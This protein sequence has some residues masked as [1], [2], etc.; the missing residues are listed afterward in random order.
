MRERLYEIVQIGEKGDV[1]SRTYDA[2]I[3][4]M[5]VLSTVSLIFPAGLMPADFDRVVRIIDIIAVYF[6]I[7]DF[8]MRWVT[9]DIHRRR[10]GHAGTWKCFILYPFTPLAIID[11]LAVLPSILFLPFGGDVLK[12]LRLLKIFRLSRGLHIVMRVIVNEGRTL[13]SVLVIMV[14]FVFV[15]ALTLYVNEPE[16]FST[17]ID[18][19]YWSSAALATIGYGDLHPEGDVGMVVNI[20]SAI[21]GVAVIA[22]PSGIIAAG[23]A[24]EAQ[25]EREAGRGSSRMLDFDFR[26]LATA[27]E[28]LTLLYQ[29]VKER[30]VHR[31]F[32]SNPKVVLYAIVLTI[33]SVL[34][35]IA[36]SHSA[37]VSA[38]FFMSSLSVTSAAI[39][40]EPTAGVLVGFFFSL[41]DALIF[42]SPI[43]IFDAVFNAAIALVVGL[44]FSRQKKI[45]AR[46]VWVFLVLGA[47]IVLVNTLVFVNSDAFLVG[48]DV[49]NTSAGS[50]VSAEDAETELGVIGISVLA[51]LSFVVN[52][53]VMGATL[54]VRRFVGPLVD[55]LWRMLCVR[56]CK[57]GASLVYPGGVDPHGP[58]AYLDVKVHPAGSSHSAEAEH[59][60]GT[61]A[62]EGVPAAAS[63][64]AGTS[65]LAAAASAATSTPAATG[66]SED[67]L[68]FVA[69]PTFA[70][71]SEP[72]FADVRDSQQPDYPHSAMRLR[73]F[74]I[75][76]RSQGE[77]PKS[78]AYDMFIA[79]T[80]LLSILP[81][82]F[83]PEN[84]PENAALFI[85]VIDAV[86]VTILILDYLLRWSVYDISL[87]MLG[88]H[89]RWRALVAYPFTPMA[90]IDILSI[91][92]TV[93]VMAEQ[94]RLL[95]LLR[96]FKLFRVLKSLSIVSNVFIRESRTLL[97]VSA[98]MVLYVFAYSVAM[99]TIEGD[100]FG[101]FLEALYWGT[102]S[103]VT[104]GYGDFHPMTQIGEM[105]N[106]VSAFVG[107]A[108]V[109]LPTGVIAGGYIDE[110]RRQ[111]EKG[112][113]G[114]H[115][116][117]LLGHEVV[118][119]VLNRGEELFGGLRNHGIRRY[120]QANPRVAV[121][122]SFLGAAA[123]AA[124][125]VFG[126]FGAA[127]GTCDTSL[128]FAYYVA[129]FLLLF[130]VTIVAIV[131]EP[132]TGVF[133]GFVIALMYALQ[134]INM[135]AVLY[136][137]CYV[138]WAVLF[139]M[140]ASVWSKMS[141]AR[142]VVTL[143]V[144]AFAFAL[145]T[146]GIDV[147]IGDVDFAV[148]GGAALFD[149]SGAITWSSFARYLLWYCILGAAYGVLALA[150]RGA[151]AVVV[152]KRFAWLAEYSGYLDEHPALASTW[153]STPAAG[154]RAEADAG[155]A[156]GAGDAA[157]G[158]A[159][160]T[161]EVAGETAGAGEATGDAAA[162]GE[163]ASCAEAA[164][165]GESSESDA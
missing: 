54:L 106:S 58:A 165:A 160:G 38:G 9:Y 67:A 136:C 112:H 65:A 22:L 48:S 28:Y 25:R 14:L 88:G 76:R 64:P 77:D 124:I 157:A 92:P 55:K 158:E 155:E 74:E 108:V 116:S 6:L 110:M 71:T 82:I 99:F 1:A 148:V 70:A 3:C 24:A 91:L 114:K 52:A 44:C 143:V 66:A 133:L 159:T 23:Y 43:Y 36:E 75:V 11:F 164:A 146:A 126:V 132:A 127:L 93:I 129:Q 98:F 154:E 80:A 95:R 57:N 31:Y 141:P 19:F 161:G 122:A 113:A 89:G 20:V 73:I 101:S 140:L 53:L 49:W 42:R 139:G 78:S 125:A 62:G 144:P 50:V 102:T 84:L 41:A 130:A 121:Y 7:F 131:L 47:L 109:A 90:I 163:V 117:I 149:A 34:C 105:F 30:V 69:E 26:P 60:A 37:G 18:A 35:V 85:R 94:F 8:I 115:R 12:L 151:A 29:K 21:L 2:L 13:I 123:V 63:A 96:L 147:A 103:L 32:V 68:T 17:F 10:T 59:D 100:T 162:A 61:S 46:D 87:E 79:I 111:R 120:F 33:C 56:A 137:F 86:T 5:S 51:L 104:I 152:R 16:T 135:G 40:L 97:S 27:R 156:A 145:L 142:I 153:R 138:L 118:E 134:I 81:L 107:V 128:D 15:F 83:A 150:A 45:R 119:A 72:Q 4:F 39:L